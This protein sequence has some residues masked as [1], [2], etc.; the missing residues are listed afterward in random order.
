MIYR[1]KRINLKTNLEDFCIDRLLL[2]V[3]KSDHLNSQV[4]REAAEFGLEGSED[5]FRREMHFSSTVLQFHITFQPQRF[6]QSYRQE[7]F[8]SLRRENLLILYTG[9]FFPRM[10]TFL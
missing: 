6:E 3:E 7:H 10:S 4:G 8:K 1:E 5:G 9:H 2:L